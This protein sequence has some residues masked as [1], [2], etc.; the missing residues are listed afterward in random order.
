MSLLRPLMVD[1][2]RSLMEMC[3]CTYTLLDSYPLSSTLQSSFTN[4]NPLQNSKS[5]SKSTIQTAQ[6]ASHA[7]MT[8]IEDPNAEPGKLPLKEQVSWRSLS[9]F[10]CA[11]SSARRVSDRL[12]EE[13]L[14]ETTRSGRRCMTRGG[15]L[16]KELIKIERRA[17]RSGV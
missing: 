9:S 17:G 16:Q 15:G 10:F 1:Q 11:L 6:D 2:H 13:G 3:L 8:V 14:E 12:W 4:C 5:K 7:G